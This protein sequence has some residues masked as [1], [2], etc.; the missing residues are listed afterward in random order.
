MSIEQQILHILALRK[1]LSRGNVY[2]GGEIILI[3][4]IAREFSR[5]PFR[6]CRYKKDHS[7]KKA[8]IQLL[9]SKQEIQ[10]TVHMN[11]SKKQ[12]LKSLMVLF[13]N[14]LGWRNKIG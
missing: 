7:Q 6:S 3:N 11:T 13:L 2:V 10:F 9:V 1:C 8:G 14:P 4:R 12:P 5:V